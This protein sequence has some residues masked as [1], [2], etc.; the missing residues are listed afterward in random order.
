[1]QRVATVLE[2]VRQAGFTA[3]QKECVVGQR[4]VQY[5]GYHLGGGQVCQ[6]M[7]K[8]TPIACCLHLKTK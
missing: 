7:D 2:S 3:N 6:H 5:L 8:T 4:E 1:M